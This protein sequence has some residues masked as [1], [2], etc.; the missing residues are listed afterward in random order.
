MRRSQQW[1]WSFVEGLVVRVRLIEA[2]TF[3]AR[4][5]VRFGG[6][7][8]TDDFWLEG[9]PPDPTNLPSGCRFRTR[10][11]RAEARCAE[12]EPPLLEKRPQHADACWFST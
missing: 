11:P 3:G 10:C 7:K 8:V 9:E 4:V 12:S 2:F 1:N 5:L 6:R